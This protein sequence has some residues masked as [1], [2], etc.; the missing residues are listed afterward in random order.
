M[1]FIAPE[2]R[3]YKA[4]DVIDI[5]N[6]VISP[7]DEK[8]IFMRRGQY[9]ITDTAEKSAANGKVLEV[10][11]ISYGNQKELVPTTTQSV[12]RFYQNANNVHLNTDDVIIIN[13]APVVGIMDK[14]V[15]VKFIEPAL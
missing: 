4:G 14:K 1:K 7:T 12:Y 5:S 6:K 13:D 15:S 2:R 8:K 10:E 3:K 11:A 9:L